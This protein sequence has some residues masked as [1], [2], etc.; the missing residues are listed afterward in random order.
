MIKGRFMKLEHL[1]KFVLVGC[2]LIA[3]SVPAQ[4]A[5]LLAI[6]RPTPDTATTAKI[7]LVNTA[8][9]TNVVL[10]DTTLTA[11]S[12]TAAGVLNTTF[13]P[14]GLA[15]DPSTG[16]AYFTSFPG[17]GAPS[18]LY[19]AVVDPPDP[20]GTTTAV[21][22][23]L[24]GRATS[25]TFYG[26]SYWYIPVGSD[27]LHKVDFPFAETALNSGGS[28]AA[29]AAGASFSFGDLTVNKDGLLF[30]H[31]RRRPPGQN[32]ALCTPVLCPVNFFTIDLE[33]ASETAILASYVE[34]GVPTEPVMQIAFA[35]EGT[36][37]GHESA[38]ANSFLYVKQ[39]VPPSGGPEARGTRSLALSEIDGGPFTD[40]SYIQPA[41]LLR[42]VR[43]VCRRAHRTDDPVQRGGQ[44]RRCG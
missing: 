35:G 17:G 33:A 12:S 8:T 31:G 9:G 25:G 19:S 37:F 22:G 24:A 2:L 32:P 44:H 27:E 16:I 40:F 36:L 13:G 14:N 28:L 23:T 26:G 11:S 6:D 38:P 20:T 43:G 7:L 5:G 18:V 1:T 10:G 34:F 29:P 15:Y 41:G 39:G 21:V 42:A 30:G 4:G 3:I